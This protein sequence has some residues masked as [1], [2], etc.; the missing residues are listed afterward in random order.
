MKKGQYGIIDPD[1]FRNPNISTGAKAIYAALA[2]YADKSRRCFPSVE[3]LMKDTGIKTRATFSK[4]MKELT[5]AGLVEKT[6]EN[7]GNLK[8]NNIYKLCDFR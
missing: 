1:V 8:S 3:K 6:R 5:N 4:H 2:I 7:K